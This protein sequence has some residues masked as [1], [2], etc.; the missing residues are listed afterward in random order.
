M[1]LAS[2]GLALLW[3]RIS[4]E[5]NVKLFF[6]C[7]GCTTNRWAFVIQTI[8]IGS[9]T[10]LCR[11]PW[12]FWCRHTV[13][14]FDPEWSWR[15]LYETVRDCKKKCV[16]LPGNAAPAQSKQP[17]RFICKSAKCWESILVVYKK[18][19]HQH[20]C[21]LLLYSGLQ[22]RHH[23]HHYVSNQRLD[24]FLTLI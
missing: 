3:A 20:Y 12:D 11:C 9:D 6:F 23:Y 18:H 2:F 8:C 15:G 5:L 14:Q 22:Y 21:C 13:I 19:R 4:I 1:H 24:C 7:S 17:L 10:L 16:P